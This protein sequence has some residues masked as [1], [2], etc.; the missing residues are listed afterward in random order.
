MQRNF[1]LLMRIAKCFK[2]D[3]ILIIVITCSHVVSALPGI[4]SFENKNRKWCYH[5]SS[6]IAIS[7]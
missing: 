3:I 6:I 2:V 5:Q 1:L 4:Y 7:V